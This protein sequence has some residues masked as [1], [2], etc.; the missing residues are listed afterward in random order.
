TILMSVVLRGERLRLMQLGALVL[1]ASGYVVVGWHS[2]SDP[3]AA[4]TLPGVAMV[5]GAAFCW[6]CANMVVGSV[7]RVHM[8]GFVAWSS[9]FPI[10]PLLLLSVSIDGTQAVAHALTHADFLL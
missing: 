4:V 7:G 6:A 2:A 1:A 10:V 5:L 3:S 8:L 9:L